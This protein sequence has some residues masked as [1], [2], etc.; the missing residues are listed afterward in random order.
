MFFLMS[1]CGDISENMLANEQRQP[2]SSKEKPLLIR[3]IQYYNQK[4]WFHLGE[5]PYI[6]GQNRCFQLGAKLPDKDILHSYLEEVYKEQTVKFDIDDYHVAD[7]IDRITRQ[8][9]CVVTMRF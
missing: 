2:G 3:S 7:Q 1:G 5:S 6:L 9:L 4:I 8:T